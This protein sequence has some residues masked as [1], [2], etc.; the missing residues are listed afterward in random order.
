MWSLVAVLLQLFLLC[1]L[2]RMVLSWFPPTGAGGAMDTVRGVLFT[3]TEP[4]LAPVRRL[5]PPVRM[6]GMGL[7][8]SVTVVFLVI[9]VLLQVLPR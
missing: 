7:D 4:V 3:V 1:L 5:L 9:L 8:L 6:G 2:G